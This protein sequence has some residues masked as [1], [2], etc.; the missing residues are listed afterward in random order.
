MISKK[1]WLFYKY[2]VMVLKSYYYCI[3][4][5]FGSVFTGLRYILVSGLQNHPNNIAK[6]QSKFFHF[7]ICLHGTV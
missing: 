6:S 5:D 1:E 7:P 3:L 4:S 2:K